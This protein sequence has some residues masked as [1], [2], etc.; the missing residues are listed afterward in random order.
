VT[1][2]DRCTHLAALDHVRVRFEDQ[3]DLIRRRHLFAIEHA[4]ARLVD[5]ARA[6]RA[7]MRDLV[8]QSLAV[9]RRARPSRGSLA[10]LP[11][12]WSCGA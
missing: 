2:L 10:G 7:I 6:E 1:E 4:A 5:D 3:I 8:A 11:K 9:G 12:R